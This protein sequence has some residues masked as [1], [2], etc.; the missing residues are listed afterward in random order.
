M[1]PFRQFVSSQD[2]FA[3]CASFTPVYV[4]SCFLSTRSIESAEEHL[5]V[6][7]FEFSEGRHGPP[8]RRQSARLGGDEEPRGTCSRTRSSPVYQH[9]QE[10][11]GQTGRHSQMGR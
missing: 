1:F 4:A 3:R 9:V 8:V 2:A 7:I 6:V 11:Q 5:R 10:A